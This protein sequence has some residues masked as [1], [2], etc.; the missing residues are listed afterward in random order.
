MAPNISTP[1]LTA[2]V[3]HE[4]KNPAQPCTTYV[5]MRRSQTSYYI[6]AALA[7]RTIA[8]AGL[9]VLFSDLGLE[10]GILWNDSR[11]M[12]LALQWLMQLV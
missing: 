11:A 8:T 12:A 5:I 2:Y 9:V 7:F 4:E 3:F 10:S 1:Q 6:F